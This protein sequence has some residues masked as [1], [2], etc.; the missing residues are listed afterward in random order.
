M[1]STASGGSNTVVTTKQRKFARDWLQKLVHC[2]TTINTPIYALAPMVDQSDLAF[3]MQCRQYGCNLCFTPMIHAKLFVTQKNYRKKFSIRQHDDDTMI[4]RPLIAQLCGSD[5]HYVLETA[6]LLQDRVDGI[7]INCGCPQNIA[8]RG[9]YGAFLLE[10]T[11][12]LIALVRDLSESSTVPISVKVRLLP[13]KR[14]NNEPDGPASLALYRELIEAG[15]SMLTIHART[16]FQKSHLTGAADW[17]IIRTAVK[18]LGP[19]VPILANGGIGN[20]QDVQN[21]L[22]FTRADGVMSSEAILEYPPLFWPLSDATKINTVISSVE[23]A[24]DYLKLAEQYPPDQQGQGNGFKTVRN[25]MH[26]FLHGA[27]Q[28]FTN[29]RDMVVRSKNIDDLRNAIG[30]LKDTHKYIG[31]QPLWYYRHR[32]HNGNH[33]DNN[34]K[35]SEETAAATI[36]ASAAVVTAAVSADKT[37]NKVVKTIHGNDIVSVLN[38]DEDHKDKEEEEVESGKRQKME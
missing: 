20:W 22:E 27:L 12:H 15:A 21:C 7:D 32:Q 23:L 1:G 19:I 33:N 5:R 18:E 26:R 6:K 17:N 14:N 4:D 10:D 29:V 35:R 31:F 13:N 34:T 11:D 37:R 30:V 2:D 9:H 28:E 36:L 38:I 8:K 3:R 16:R 25:H 24:L